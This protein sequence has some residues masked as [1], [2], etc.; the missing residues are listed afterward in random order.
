MVV[1][2][3]RSQYYTATTNTKGIYALAEIPSASSYTITVTK[4][5]YVFT[6]KT[7]TTGTSRDT[8]SISGNKWQ[9]DFVGTAFTDL[10]A[11]GDVDS[12]DFATLASSWL[13]GPGDA[14]WNPRCDISSPA[15][16]FVNALDLA[17]F[18]K[19]WLE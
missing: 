9:V 1:A 18:A 4:A 3:R 11:D 7:V 15:D 2:Q 8:R 16:D 17:E 14:E 12:A 19:D 5:G 13:A 10:D 6:N